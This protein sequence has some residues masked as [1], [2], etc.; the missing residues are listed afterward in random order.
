MNGF[1]VPINDLPEHLV[2]AWHALMQESMTDNPFF[3]PNNLIPAARH[4]QGGSE[5]CLAIAEE[6]GEMFAAIPIR[7]LP[8]W[9]DL[10][11]A[12][13]S[14]RGL[15]EV[16]LALGTP[17][18]SSR[19]PAEAATALLL[20]LAKSELRA[21]IL[22][23]E[24][25]ESESPVAPWLH[26]AARELGI[27]IYV[28]QR[29]E[30]PVLCRTADGEA[31]TIARSRRREIARQERRLE[32]TLGDKIKLVDHSG[33]PEWPER[34]LQLEAA[35]WKGRMAPGTGA[36]LHRSG[37][38]SWFC[39]SALKMSLSGAAA[40]L[41]LEINA[42][43]VAMAYNLISESGNVFAYKMCFDEAF[44]QNAPGVLLLSRMINLFTADSRGTYFDSSTDPHNTYIG[45]FFPDKK[46]MATLVFGFGN[47]FSR[48]HVQHASITRPFVRHARRVLYYAHG[49][50]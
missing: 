42:H 22:A 28:Y 2:N 45:E 21:G 3:H 6:A 11:T 29:W 9:E 37:G 48:L 4:V 41:S 19:Y 16:S 32:A 10:G 31:P 24:Y 27:P 7:R 33:D 15:R 47:K 25:F 20:S 36:I 34:F 13:V 43:T 30:R 23:L 26:D 39:E 17:L 44:R 14:P 18:L 49:R 12:V 46:A 40:F 1:V 38:A 50:T 5:L 8:R 35:G